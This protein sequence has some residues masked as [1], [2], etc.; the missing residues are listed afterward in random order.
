ME[1]FNLLLISLIVL[2]PS[3]VC[4]S[5]YKIPAIYTFG[6]S[7]LDAGNN[8]FNKNCSAQAD[9]P[10]YGSSF[11]HQPTGRFTNGRTVVDF[12]SQFLGIDIQEPYLEAEMGVANGSRKAYP[13]N[14]INFASGGSGVLPQT[15]KDLGVIPIQDQ[16]QQFQTLVNEN[17]L[18]KK[19]VQ[20][21]LFLFESGSNDIFNYYNP[22]TGPTNLDPEAYVQAMLTQVK[23]F[24]DQIYSLGARRIVIIAL[25]PVGCV[26]ARM[27]LPGGRTDRCFGR[28]N[29]IVKKYNAGLEGL[30][31]DTP[32]THPGAIGVYGEVYKAVQEFRSM[33][34]RYGFFNITGACCGDGTLRGLVQCGKDSYKVCENPNQFLFWDFFHPSEHTYELVSKALWAGKQSRV[35]P[36]NLRTL[37]SISV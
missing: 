34:K 27:L 16:V 22:F 35:R 31:K 8:R 32:I 3:V 18:D 6:D 7:I 10:P 23:Q 11:F 24:I 21:S 4:A 17:K 37:A 15:N 20:K 12:L 29:H 25:G 30:V 13:S 28:I 19:L 5:S 26:P 36:I 1:S 9:F 14:G 33:P 2:V